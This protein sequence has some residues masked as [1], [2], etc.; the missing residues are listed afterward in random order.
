MCVGGSVDVC[1]CEREN[2][3]IRD[4]IMTC[5]FVYLTFLFAVCPFIFTWGY[6]AVLVVMDH[7]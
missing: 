5:T 2:V 1:V 7:L 4:N 6:F 3:F